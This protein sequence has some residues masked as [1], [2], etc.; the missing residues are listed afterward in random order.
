MKNVLYGNVC[1][2]PGGRY[3]FGRMPTSKVFISYPWAQ[4]IMLHL[5]KGAKLL[6][7]VR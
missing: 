6:H 4:E 1:I 2:R 7:H 3:G 5:G